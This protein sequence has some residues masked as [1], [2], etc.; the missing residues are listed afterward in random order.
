MPKL[1]AIQLIPALLLLILASCKDDVINPPVSQ[2]NYSIASVYH[3]YASTY[4][5]QLAS[6]SFRTYAFIA[7]GSSGMQIVDVTAPNLP[8]SVSSLNTDGTAAGITLAVINGYL[9]AFIVDYNGGC[10]IA[11]VSNPF[12][13]V[14]VADLNGLF[15]SAVVDVPNEWLYLGS[16]NGNILLVDI[17]NL[18]FSP[19]PRLT[20]GTSNTPVNSLYLAGSSLFCA[21]GAAGMIIYN[22]SSPLNPDLS[23]VANTTGSANDVTASTGYAYVA[24]GFNGTVIF[25][26]TDPAAPTLLS[27]IAPNSEILSIAVNN[28]TLYTADNSYGSE[29]FDIFSTSSPVKNGYIKLNSS[30][31]DIVYFGGYL[32]LAAAE[33]GLAILQ[34]VN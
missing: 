8:D 28:N 18:P 34:P 1:K 29:S 7:D 32:Y 14:E 12:L 17:S 16:D 27:T 24:D 19:T 33:G 30:A 15:L 25:N 22:V 6:I 20:F 3:T 11:D 2:S 4:A 9:F 26:V 31:L 21:A 10:V 5:V 23:S 13:P